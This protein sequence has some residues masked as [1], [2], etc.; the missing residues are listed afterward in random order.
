MG[1]GVISIPPTNQGERFSRLGTFPFHESCHQVLPCHSVPLTLSD[2]SLYQ[3][4]QFVQMCVPSLPRPVSCPSSE[5]VRRISCCS[6]GF[7]QGKEWQCLLS[8]SPP[9]GAGFTFLVRRR[10]TSYLLLGHL[11]APLARCSD[12]PTQVLTRGLAH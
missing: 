10:N 9:G 4:K 5:P 12:T 3:G 8:V 1:A 11:G 2:C 7:R 6:N